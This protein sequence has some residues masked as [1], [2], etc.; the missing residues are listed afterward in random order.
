M[1]QKTLK[2]KTELHFYTILVFKQINFRKIN[3]ILDNR[4]ADISRPT[5]ML[6][7]VFFHGK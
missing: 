4:I 6:Q 3:F 7:F 5:L 2:D 1:L